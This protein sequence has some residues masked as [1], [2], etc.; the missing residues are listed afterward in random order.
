MITFTYAVCGRAFEYQGVH[1]GVR[2]QFVGLGS[3]FP[4]CGFKRFNLGCQ[5]PI[6]TEPFHQPKFPI[7]K[8]IV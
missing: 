1:V 5:V 7:F 4:P 8:F 2:G 6:S 3:L